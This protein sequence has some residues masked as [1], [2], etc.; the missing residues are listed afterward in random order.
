MV[1]TS[2][3]SHPHIIHVHTVCIYIQ[4]V[5]VGVLYVICSTVYSE[6]FNTSEGI[7]AALGSEDVHL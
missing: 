7:K 6:Y 1:V 4:Y 5:G 2:I 3:H